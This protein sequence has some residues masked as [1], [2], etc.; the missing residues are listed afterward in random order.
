MVQGEQRPVGRGE[1]V[2]DALFRRVPVLSAADL[3]RCR[4]LLERQRRAKRREFDA[5]PGDPRAEA[6]WL[7]LDDPESVDRIL[8]QW[9]PLAERGRSTFQRRT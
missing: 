4:D 2:A 9:R 5:P 8:E 3:D 1:A 7:L 6:E